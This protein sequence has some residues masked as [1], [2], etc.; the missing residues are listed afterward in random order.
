MPIVAFNRK[1]HFKKKEKKKAFSYKLNYPFMVWK[2][3][4]VQPRYPAAG[5]RHP[6]MPGECTS[7]KPHIS[8]LG[9]IKELL[10]GDMFYQR[11]L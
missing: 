7:I 4:H 8:L 5:D 11:Q 3:G 6:V 2:L 1:L 10:V 9:A